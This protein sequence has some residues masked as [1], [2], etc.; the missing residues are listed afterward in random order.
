MTFM[1]NGTGTV[2]YSVKFELIT[3]SENNAI[4]LTRSLN[5]FQRIKFAKAE[6][7]RIKNLRI[8]YKPRTGTKG[9]GRIDMLVRDNRIDADMDDPIINRCDILASR[10]AVITWSSCIW[11]AKSDLNESEDP[12]IMF[13]IELSECNMRPNYSIGR[14]VINVELS[15]SMNMDGFVHRAPTLAIGDDTPTVRGIQNGQEFILK[16]LK[17]KS[18]QAIEGGA[19]RR[20]NDKDE[21][22]KVHLREDALNRTSSSSSRSSVAK[23]FPRSRV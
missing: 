8:T 4:S 5:L 15:A 3:G 9:K 6:N 14:S 1:F 16:H 23:K 13:E 17:G 2:S 12:P 18:V 7:V 11:L 21:E 10:K 20:T 22:T 19:T